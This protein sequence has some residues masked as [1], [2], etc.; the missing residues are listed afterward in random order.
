MQPNKLAS[1]TIALGLVALGLG[2]ET[3]WAAPS[4]GAGTVAALDPALTAGRG[5]T[6]PFVEQ[7]AENA[8]TNGTITGPDRTAYTLPA[9]A[10]GRKAVKLAPG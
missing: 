9:E 3:A 2:A 6:V 7:E 10:S 4:T 1:V 5:A 8:T